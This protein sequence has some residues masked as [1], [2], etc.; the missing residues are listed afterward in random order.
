MVQACNHLNRH[1]RMR[2][3]ASGACVRP[4]LCRRLEKSDWD[5]MRA[6]VRVCTHLWPPMITFVNNGE[7]G[8]V[9]ARDKAKG[10]V[11][12][13]DHIHNKFPHVFLLG[14]INLAQTL[15]T[16]AALN[17]HWWKYVELLII[18]CSGVINPRIHI[19]RLLFQYW[20]P[21]R[22][23]KGSYLLK[24]NMPDTC[25]KDPLRMLNQTRRDIR[26]EHR[27][28]RLLSPNNNNNNNSSFPILP[29]VSVIAHTISGI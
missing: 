10:R 1:T 19:C 11:G 14:L 21:L 18:L 5:Y 6:C 15:K 23:D 7:C 26:I 13:P 12:E 24:R 20:T 9:R 8:K 3:Q 29:L 2:L 25:F 22:S 28:R 4:Y 17:T 27:N 16:R